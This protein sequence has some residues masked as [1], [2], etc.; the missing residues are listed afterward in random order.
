LSQNSNGNRKKS[1]SFLNNTNLN[2]SSNKR[3]VFRKI[4][5]EYSFFVHS[6]NVVRKILCFK[7][8]RRLFPIKVLNNKEVSIK[9]LIK[10]IIQII[11][12]TAAFKTA[13]EFSPSKYAY[14]FLQDLCESEN[15]CE[16]CLCNEEVIEYLIKPM[17]TIMNMKKSVTSSSSNM[18]GFS[19]SS[20]TY[21]DE[22]CMLIVANVLSK[23]AS[24]QCGYRQL[25]FNDSK[26]NFSTG[27]VKNS[28]AY[29]IVSFVKKALTNQLSYS[30]S[31][32][33]IA[34]Y[35]Y[36]TR[37]LYS[38]CE[39][40]YLVKEYDLN[41]SI[42]ESWRLIS[43]YA[44]SSSSSTNPNTPRQATPIFSITLKEMFTFSWSESLLDNLV[45]MASTPK[46]VYYLNETGLLRQV[47]NY[48]FTRYKSKLQ[49]GKYEKFGYGFIVSQLSNT[50][51]GCFYLNEASLI[52]FLI[53]EIW[54]ELEYGSDDFMSAF[55]RSYSVE[56]IDKEIYKPM[57]CLMNIL[58]S[59]SAV[60]ELLADV[61]ITPRSNYGARDM[62]KGL[63]VNLGFF[64]LKIS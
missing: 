53:D 16:A 3:T 31:T 48:M 42:S 29:T 50:P 55:P 52:Q 8:G 32:G 1:N 23:L 17:K 7:N 49:V 60:Y 28:A 26:K 44:S 34:E 43:N 56:I 14:D 59:F 64:S 9:D 47:V 2:N 24:T 10:T 61:T 20:G 22:S 40:V 62:P 51:S 18:T 33:E 21:Y 27:L 15:T 63:I 38:Q 39:G 6:L 35:L 37:L 25:I 12:E 58:S 46:G 57:L 5:I 11:F 4:E 45:S 19:S 13:N 54:T 36:L 41:K 30:I